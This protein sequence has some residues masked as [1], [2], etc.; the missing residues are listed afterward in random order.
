MIKE[1]QITKT[2]SVSGGE[3]CWCRCSLNIA[4][5]VGMSIL[6]KIQLGY[7]LNR[8]KMTDPMPLNGVEQCKNYCENQGLKM[9]DCP[10]RFPAGELPIE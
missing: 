1:I 7:A 6:K 10:S 8:G 2:V 5:P 3:N 4:A 9:I